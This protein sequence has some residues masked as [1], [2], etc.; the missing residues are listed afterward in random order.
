MSLLRGK[1][2]LIFLALWVAGGRRPYPR[3]LS[4]GLTL[5]WMGVGGLIIYLVAGPDPEQRLFWF[6]SLLVAF[7]V[8]LVLVGLT[9]VVSQSFP[10]WRAGKNWSRRL[11]KVSCGCACPAD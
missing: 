5:G 10:A 1:G 8:G 4:I 7:W 2:L 11:E 6:A 9:V 3:W